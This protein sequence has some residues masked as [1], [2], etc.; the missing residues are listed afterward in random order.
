MLGCEVS[1]IRRVLPGR[2]VLI[3]FQLLFLL[4]CN[5]GADQSKTPIANTVP[6]EPGVTRI[7][8]FNT[9]QK[10]TTLVISGIAV[11]ILIP[12]QHK[13]DLL[14]LPGW[15]YS[16]KAP[17]GDIPLTQ[18]LLEKGYRLI[19]PEMS[20][21]VYASNYF[22]ETRKDWRKYPT[23]EWVT[24][25][26]IPLL[27]NKFAFL[28]E[29]KKS[30]IMGI[31]TGARGTVLI[32]AKKPIFTAGA[33]LSGDYDQTQMPGDNLMKGVYGEYTNFK[34]RWETV[35]NPAFQV[36]QIKTP[37]YLGH[38]AK[39][40]VVPAQQTEH[41]YERLHAAQPGLKVILSIKADAGHDPAY[42][43]SEMEHVL[44]FFDEVANK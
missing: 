2:T 43:M 30:F 20:K 35:D 3:V 17:F 27:Q 42:W 6:A 26:M 25:T 9:I 8:P 12:A 36:D 37:L 5:Q 31:S 11:D 29:G 32:S 33:A 7:L 18:M 13:A 16:R 44:L 10:D 34:E 40:K 22:P 28:S 15:N 38:G 14:V 21:S 1:L 24:D 39:D 23:L 4:S 41:Y 19:L